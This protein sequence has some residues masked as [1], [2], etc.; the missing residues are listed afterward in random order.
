MS[1]GTASSTYYETEET[2]SSYRDEERLNEEE[3]VQK[4]QPTQNVVIKNQQ[5][6]QVQSARDLLA[7]HQ[8]QQQ[9]QSPVKGIL[10]SP[11]PSLYSGSTQF[12]TDSVASSKKSSP[13]SVSIAISSIASKQTTTPST[14]SANY[15][16]SDI[17]F[18]EE[19][20]KAFKMI[21]TDGDELISKNELAVAI[22]SYGLDPSPKYI[23]ELF[24]LAGSKDGLLDMNQFSTLMKKKVNHVLFEND[25]KKRK[26]IEVFFDKLDKNGDGYL[27]FDEFKEA[28]ESIPTNGRMNPKQD[29]E[30]ITEILT[31]IDKNG[32]GVIDIGGE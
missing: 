31:N 21:D 27:S 14:T 29:V 10:H 28:L 3:V 12:T 30:V 8:Q 16:R 1:V 11:S 32:D 7:A 5:P 26:A 22:R 4:V 17:I 13:K 24:H 23:N 19:M 20:K 25:N 18:V 2:T 9:T 6:K 15:N